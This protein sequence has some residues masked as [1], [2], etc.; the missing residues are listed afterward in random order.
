MNRHS[1]A[2]LLLCAVLG[3]VAAGC[4][5]APVPVSGRLDGRAG[6]TVEISFGLQPQQMTYTVYHLVD[7]DREMLWL[8]QP[9]RE[10]EANR[11]S[12]TFLVLREGVATLTFEKTWAHEGDWHGRRGD[13]LDW[14][15]TAEPVREVLGYEIIDMRRPAVRGR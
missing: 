1:L 3:A 9:P 10:D 13:R 4:A 2:C 15:R 14:Q 5:T 8:V 12:G 6:E 7:Y 11:W